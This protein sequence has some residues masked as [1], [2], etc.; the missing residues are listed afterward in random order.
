M[1]RIVKRKTDKLI[2]N[3]KSVSI[4]SEICTNSVKLVKVTPR[5]LRLLAGRT[6]TLDCVTMLQRR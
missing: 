2:I 3:G 4:A 6:L 5:G 1:K